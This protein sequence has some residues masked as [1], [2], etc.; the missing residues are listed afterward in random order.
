MR[1]AHQPASRPYGQLS[2]RRSLQLDRHLKQRSFT[3]RAFT[4][5]YRPD[6]AVEPRR[7]YG[8]RVAALRNQATHPTGAPPVPVPHSSH[9]RASSSV[10]VSVS[11]WR[12]HHPRSSIL[13]GFPVAIKSRSSTNCSTVAPMAC[14]CAASIRTSPAKARS[15][16]ASVKT[17]SST[18]RADNGSFAVVSRMA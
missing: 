14:R 11:L 6:R 15:R 3:A 17:A 18:A 4:R 1:N 12:D 16:S 10:A 13:Q 8:T 5:K 2:R 7:L 9:Q